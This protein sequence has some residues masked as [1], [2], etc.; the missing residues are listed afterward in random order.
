[1]N[2]LFLVLFASLFSSQFNSME[3][4]EIKW[5]VGIEIH[6]KDMFA[7]Q[8][9]VIDDELKI[10]IGEIIKTVLPIVIP[11][12]PTI[13][14]IIAPFLSEEDMEPELV[15]YDRDE[16][17]ELVL[18]ELAE[19]YEIDAGFWSSVGGFIKQIAP[20]VIKTV[21][22]MIPT[23]GPILAPLTS[24]LGEEDSDEMIANMT[25]PFAKKIQLKPH[26]KPVIGKK[27]LPQQHPKMKKYWKKPTRRTTAVLDE[28]S[29][30]GILK[31]ILPVV[32]PLIHSRPHH[33]PIP[34]RRGFRS[35]CCF[36]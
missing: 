17:V 13:G 36:T 32:V 20:I 6:N 4:G 7:P 21:V 1:M 11:K 30:G 16:L 3:D 18:A 26:R 34:Q 28:I 5:K 15:S 31:K 19:E 8:F 22:P 33:C 12:I 14:P 27:R 24:F 9:D 23:V 29:L 10:K 25:N 35:S 2:T